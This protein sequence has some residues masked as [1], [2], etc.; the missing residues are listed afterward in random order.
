MEF[1]GVE[2][3]YIIDSI[4]MNEDG[5]S[6]KKNAAFC[7]SEDKGLL[8]DAFPLLKQMIDKRCNHSK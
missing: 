5:T 8:M 2:M 7:P 6:F 3:N 4:I 1:V